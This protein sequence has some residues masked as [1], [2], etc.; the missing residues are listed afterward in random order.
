MEYLAHLWFPV[1]QNPSQFL[2]CFVFYVCICGIWKLLGQGS[3]PHSHRD[4]AGSFL[5]HSRKSQSQFLNCIKHLFNRILLYENILD[6]FFFLFRAAPIAYGSSQAKGPIRARA[7]HQSHS[8]SNTG[9]KPHLQPT[10]QLMA[11]ADPQP[12]E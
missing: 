7:A 8:H 12:T 1:L 5:P 2:F 9:C 4:N 10:T 11:S 6:F 3:N